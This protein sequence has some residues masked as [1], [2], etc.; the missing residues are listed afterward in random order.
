MPSVCDPEQLDA[1]RR[2]KAT[3]SRYQRNRDLLAVGAYV[4]G[5][6]PALDQAIAAYPGMDRFL[7]QDMREHA[8][9]GDAQ[10][11]LQELSERLG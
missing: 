9:L 1:A 8:A 3:F 6:D 4:P 11:Q 10:A 5:A 7:V 2:F